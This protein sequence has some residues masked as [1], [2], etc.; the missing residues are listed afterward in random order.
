MFYSQ[1]EPLRSGARTE[2]GRLTF[3]VDR[4]GKEGGGVGDERLEEVCNLQCFALEM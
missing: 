4:W 1:L 2:E 3:R